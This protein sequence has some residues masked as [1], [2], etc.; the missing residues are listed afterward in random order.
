MGPQAS[1]DPTPDGPEP[2]AMVDGLDAFIERVLES[3]VGITLLTMA[4]LFPLLV[5]VVFPLPARAHIVLSL[6][7]VAV[8]LVVNARFPRMRLVIVILSLAA[9]GRYLLYRG[10]ET[11]AWGSWTDITTSLLLYGA[12]L[13]ALVTLMSGYFQTAIIRRNKPVPISGLAASQLPTVDIY[14]PTYN[15]HA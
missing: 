3:P 4:C 2:G 13:Y 15:E 1:P 9:S 12:E 6:L 14:I 11:L 5:F 7:I 10:A 8:A